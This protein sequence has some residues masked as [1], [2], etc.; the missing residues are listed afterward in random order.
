[1]TA[2]TGNVSRATHAAVT[3]LVTGF[4]GQAGFDV[5][6]RPYHE[7]ISDTLADGGIDGDVRGLQDVFLNVTSRLTHRLDLDLDRARVGADVSGKRVACF[8]QWRASRPVA[9]SYA[10]L[11]LRDLARLMGGTPPPP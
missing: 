2:A 6:S 5:R 9:E 11:S 8:V 3:D 4:L 10:V 7:R 1:M